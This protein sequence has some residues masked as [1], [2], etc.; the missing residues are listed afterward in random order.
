MDDP[1]SEWWTV[2]LGARFRLMPDRDPRN[3][4]RLGYIRVEAS[5]EFDRGKATGGQLKTSFSV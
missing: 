1:R 2:G 4:H 3:Q 5:L